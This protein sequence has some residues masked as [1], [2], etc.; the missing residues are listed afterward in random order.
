MI[1]VTEGDQLA[2]PATSQPKKSLVGQ[3]RQPHSPRADASG[4]SYLSH[5]ISSDRKL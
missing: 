5:P 2:R 4:G 1:D 3:G